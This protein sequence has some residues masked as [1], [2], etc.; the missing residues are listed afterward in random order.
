VTS[1][2]IAAAT[3]PHTTRPTPVPS[4]LLG[5]FFRQSRAQGDFWPTVFGGGIVISAIFGFWAFATGVT[6]D[7][8]VP[9]V[10]FL[11]LVVVSIPICIRTAGR[12]IDRRLLKILLLAFTLKMLCVFPRYAVSEYVYKGDG[13][14]YGYF[15][16]GR[17]LYDNVHHGHWSLEGSLIAPFPDETRT[18]GYVT[19]VLFL[20]FG[21]TYM[22]GYIIFTWL[23][24]LGLVFFFRAFRIA[25]PNAPPY[26]GAVLI[27]LLPSVLYWPS[28]LGKDAVMVFAIGLMTLGLS[29]L[30]TP[31][32]P[33][34]GILWAAG[35]GYLISMIRPHLLAIA[36]VGVVVSFL[37]RNASDRPTRSRI[38]VRI[39]LLVL[40]VPGLFFA[41][42]RLDHAFG[43]EK[44]ANISISQV[45]D[46]TNQ[47]TSIGGSSFET[48]P[49]KSPLDVPTAIFSVVYRP[50]IF[51]ARSLPVFISAAEGSALLVLTVVSIRWIWR[52]GPAMYRHPFAAYCG[53]Y[54]VAFVIAFSNVGNAGILARQR[55]QMFPLLMVLVAAAHEHYRL[56][57]PD[58]L[59]DDA[60]APSQP[61]TEPALLPT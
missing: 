48:E 43:T 13:D 6:P 24:W 38:A 52:I 25:F 11:A 3:L 51:E 50:F 54:V 17:V 8:W 42:S 47:Q 31:S 19:G 41:L 30:L 4:P 15:D 1:G 7:I 5:G 36:L 23:S 18:V 61:S 32:K 9:A 28:S 10:I 37:A 39:L 45:L 27:F 44:S 49:V 59:L 34:V 29:R 20:V 58:H 40:L 57:D 16:G 26:R 53:A 22:G 14:A 46:K 60:E 12:P 21:T 55:V 2:P 35:G 56:A 33:L